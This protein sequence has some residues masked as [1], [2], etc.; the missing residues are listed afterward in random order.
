REIRER[1]TAEG[2]AW[3]EGV[4]KIEMHEFLCGVRLLAEERVPAEVRGVVAERLRVLGEGI[5]GRDE[6]AWGGYGL[7]PLQVAPRRDSVLAD[8][9]EGD[10]EG[11]LRYEVG[12]QETGGGWGPRWSWGMFEKEWEV[13]KRA[14]RGVLTVE[15]VAGMESWG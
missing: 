10:M 2:V 14:W 6:A 1:V 7:T 9:V 3:L 15:M 4:E 13:A 12:R 5:L 11:Y 8:W